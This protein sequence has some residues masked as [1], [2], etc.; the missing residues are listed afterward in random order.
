M[1]SFLIHPKVFIPLRGL[2]HVKAVM[3][4]EL[5]PFPQVLACFDG[6]DFPV[7]GMESVNPLAV[8]IKAVIDFVSQCGGVVLS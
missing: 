5:V 4:E 1:K 8:G 3:Y 7:A 2:I 6:R